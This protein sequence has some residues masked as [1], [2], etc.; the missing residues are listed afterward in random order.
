MRHRAA[1]RGLMVGHWGN[2]GPISHF[3]VEGLAERGVRINGEER[4]PLQVTEADL[5]EAD[6]VIAVKEGEHRPLMR[7]L[8][9]HWADEIEYWH[10]DDLDCAGP[11]EALPV[12][13]EHVRSL[14]VKLDGN[15]T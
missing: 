7:Q 11:G 6:L 15:A 5:A 1:L 4:F 13:E 10:I 14:L 3:A 9:P 12:L 2:I 8:F